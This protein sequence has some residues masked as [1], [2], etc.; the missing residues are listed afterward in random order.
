MPNSNSSPTKVVR[1]F[2]FI[3]RVLRMFHSPAISKLLRYHQDNPNNDDSVMKSVADSL[4]WKHITSEHVDPTFAL[5]PRN[6]RLGLSLDGMNPFPQSNTTHSTW[7][8]LL[9]IYN[10]PPYLVTKKFFIQLS[11]LISGKESLTSEN[12]GVFIEPLLE[13]LQMLWIGVRAQDF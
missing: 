13:E 12:I 1:W 2:P 6:L 8:V 10:L 3:P 9:L 5:E 11:I 4:A 7:P